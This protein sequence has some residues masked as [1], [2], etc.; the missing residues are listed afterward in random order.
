MTKLTGVS[1]LMM[2]VVSNDNNFN[3]EEKMSGGVTPMVSM[4]PGSD[5]LRLGGTVV[6]RIEGLIQDRRALVGW[7]E[8][9]SVARMGSGVVWELVVGGMNL[10]MSVTVNSDRNEMYNTRT[11]ITATDHCCHLRLRALSYNIDCRQVLVLVLYL[12]GPRH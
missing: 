10:V 5:E 7:T 9:I 3:V 8:F 12:S 2:Q 6:T 4:V 11:T 1:K